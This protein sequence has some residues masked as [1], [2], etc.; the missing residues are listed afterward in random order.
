M[1]PTLKYYQLRGSLSFDSNRIFDG[2][3][4]GILFLAFMFLVA[5]IVTIFIYTGAGE[6]IAALYSGEVIFAIKLSLFTATLSAIL[7]MIV[8][9]PSAY[10]LSR[11]DFPGKVIVN[12]TLNLPIVLPPTAVGAILLIFFTTSPGSAGESWFI[13]F[14]YAVPGIILAQFVI[15]TAL[16]IRVMKPAFDDLDPEY[17]QVART[18]GKDKFQTFFEVTLPMCK[19]AVAGAAVLAWARAIGE[20]GATVMLAGATRMKTETMP[21]AIFLNFA[22][23]DIPQVTALILILIAI[24]ISVLYA[25]QKVIGGYRIW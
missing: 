24:S 14:T 25:V 2:A 19:G 6:L 23:A 15:V 12:S 4:A 21:I 16:A 20:F 22:E 10:A 1:L 18:L 5:L 8:A 17:E 3:I 11:F 9:I 13:E 7:S